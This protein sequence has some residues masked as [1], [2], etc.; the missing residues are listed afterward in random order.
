MKKT[1]L[2]NTS[3][4]HLT[5]IVKDKDGNFVFEGKQEPIVYTGGL[6]LEKVP[7]KTSIVHLTS[8]SNNPYPEW[9]MT[10]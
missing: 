1:S 7:T 9:G 3:S 2:Y 5:S 8:D 6:V 10:I 4:C